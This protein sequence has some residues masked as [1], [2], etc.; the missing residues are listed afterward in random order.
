MAE[1]NIYMTRDKTSINNYFSFH[2]EN[3]SRVEMVR[4]M[5]SVQSPQHGLACWV[6]KISKNTIGNILLSQQNF[7]CILYFA[8]VQ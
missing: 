2:I 6:T 7:R 4:K 8:T 1:K 5:F 3:I